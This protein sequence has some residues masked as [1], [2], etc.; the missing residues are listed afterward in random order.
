MFPDGSTRQLRRQ[1][2][3]AKVLFRDEHVKDLKPRGSGRVEKWREQH[4]G[5]GSYGT[6]YRATW[7]GKEVAV[8]ELQ[9]PEET[10]GMTD[11]ERE[12]FVKKA[13]ELRDEFIKELK[14]SC[15][16]ASSTSVL[17]L[18]HGC[19]SDFVC[20]SCVCSVAPEPGAASWVGYRLGTRGAT[21]GRA[22]VP[23]WQSTTS[24]TRKSGN[25]P[26]RKS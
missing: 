25:H 12:V 9:V 26:R 23:W 14:V 7:K 16:R 13:H 2:S 8:K 11:K 1:A 21:N 18:S 15:D 22:G 24:S 5:K 3:P 6:V 19:V 20:A 10:P 17:F 4:I